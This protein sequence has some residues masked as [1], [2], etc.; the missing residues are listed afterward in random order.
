MSTTKPTL[1]RTFEMPFGDV[2]DRIPAALKTEGFGVLT[3]IDVRA[4]MK[5]KLDVDFPAYTI[6]GACNPKMAH[7]ALTMD[8]TIGVNLP[9][10]VVVRDLGGGKVEVRAVDPVQT[11]GGAGHSD[12]EGLAIQVREM[13][14][15]AI[16]AI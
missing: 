12:L 9:C 5:A 1:V 2:L 3:T 15:R 7:K 8:P 16:A 13:L 6:L 10:N 14:A 4:T 11:I